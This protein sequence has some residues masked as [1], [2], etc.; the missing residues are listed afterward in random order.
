MAADLRGTVATSLRPNG[1]GL[2]LREP[3]RWSARLAAVI[4][5]LT[6]LTG[7]GDRRPAGGDARCP[8]PEFIGAFAAPR[9]SPAPPAVPSGSSWRR[10]GRRT[11]SAGSSETIGLLFAI[12]GFVEAY[13]IASV[14]IAD[15]AL[16]GMPGMTWVLTW[17]WVPSVF[18]ALVFLPLLF[19]DRPTP[20]AD[21]ATGRLVGRRRTGRRL[22]RGGGH[23]R[24]DPADPALRQP[25]GRSG[26]R[27]PVR[28]RDHRDRDHPDRR[29]PSGWRSSRWCG[30]TARPV[31][32]S[33]IKIRWFA[34]AAGLAGP[35]FALYVISYLLGLPDVDQ[36]FREHRGPRSELAMPV[37]A[38]IAILRYRLYE[39]DRIIS[40]TISYGVVTSLLVGA[41]ALAILVLQG[42]LASLTGGQTIAVALSTLVAAA[43]FQPLRVRVQRAVDRRFDRARFDAERTSASFAE[44]LRVEVDIDAVTDDLRDTVRRSIKP[45]GLGLW[46]RGGGR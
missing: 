39:I 20:V 26:L 12:E 35:V 13:A 38:G 36:S 21:V 17:M 32:R 1:L 18:L 15:T 6:G 25:A 29:A 2:W 14:T 8:A 46:L 33:T 40:R 43:L 24:T 7:S 41:Y 34:F 5:I 16:P 44:R 42:P 28:Q 27:P 19:P 11:G 37:A 23:A 9:S 45:A 31:T 22:D 4:G 10:V 30:A 3:A